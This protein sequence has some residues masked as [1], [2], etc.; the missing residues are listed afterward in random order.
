ME[1]S[2][3]FWSR[4]SILVE[5]DDRIAVLATLPKTVRSVELSFLVFIDNMS[6]K[7][8][9]VICWTGVSIL[10]PRDYATVT[11]QYRCLDKAANEFI[12]SDGWNSFERISEGLDSHQRAK[13][14]RHREI[15]RYPFRPGPDGSPM[16]NSGVKKSLLQGGTMNAG[17]CWSSKKKHQTLQQVGFLFI[18]PHSGSLDNTRKAYIITLLDWTAADDVNTTQSSDKRTSNIY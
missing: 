2:T 12:Y 3:P 8:K 7:K 5:V 6:Q 13:E 4:G 11:L 9:S 18:K 17:F 16:E 15:L 10:S 14:Y 1:E